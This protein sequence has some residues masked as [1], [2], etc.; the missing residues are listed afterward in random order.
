MGLRYGKR[1]KL[2]P[3]LYVN[4]SKSGVS[5]S[6]KAGPVTFNR[7]SK[8]GPRTTINLPGNFSYVMQGKGKRSGAKA[9]AGPS[10][11]PTPSPTALA[12]AA[13]PPAA[14]PAS[15]IPTP[16][17]LAPAVEKRFAQGLR[18]LVEGDPTTAAQRF[19]EAVEA[20]PN[21]RHA[22]DDFLAGVA[23]MQ[24][25]QFEVAIPY[26]ERVVEGETD[27]PDE[28]MQ[29][30]VGDLRILCGIT[31]QVT[32]DVPMTN[33]GAALLLSEGYQQ[34]GDLFGATGVLE[35][36]LDHAPG[37]PLLRLSLAELYYLQ[38][39]H[40]G[41]LEVTDGLT[42]DTEIGYGALIF[43]AQ[44]LL[45]QGHLDAALQVVNGLLRD[46]RKRPPQFVEDALFT[47]GMIYDAKG[48]ADKARQDFEKLY[49]QNTGYPGLK[50]WLDS[51][52]A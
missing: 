38:G 14:P 26:L 31:P 20:D 7:G 28:M 47:R 39:H 16:G 19:E 1:I 40:D 51:L 30:Y 43:R 21:D 2:G 35:E 12:P 25:G 36:L 27:L 49:A 52:R 6:V 15:T 23:L 37:E 44:T 48:Q 10:S 9:K 8:R 5:W 50:E 22:S 18:A 34:T 11:E 41:V 42:A 33:V 4:L 29:R 32:V 3:G 13:T 24:A 45:A 17:F 46:R